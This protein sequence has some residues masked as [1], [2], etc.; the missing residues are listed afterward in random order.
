M[1]ESLLPYFN[2]HQEIKVEG[3][4]LL[5]G[6]RVIV[7]EKLKQRV[8]DELHMDHLGIVRMKS[9]ARNYIW[10]PGVDQNIEEVLLSLSE[11][12]EYST[13]SPT[14]PMAL[15]HQAMEEN[16]CRFCRSFPEE[17]VSASHRRTFKVA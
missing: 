15:A 4:C 8:L 3:G 14:A 13:S 2:K 6:I 17:N 9:K 10:W 11:S 1:D 7:L 16:T 5:W 12:E